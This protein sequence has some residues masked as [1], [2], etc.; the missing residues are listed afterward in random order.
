MAQQ[1]RIMYAGNFTWEELKYNGFTENSLNIL[2]NDLKYPIHPA[3]AYWPELT[4]EDQDILMPTIRLASALF[5]SPASVSFLEN[6]M[7]EERVYLHAESQQAGFN[8][9]GLNQCL[10]PT[11]HIRGLWNQGMRELSDKISWRIFDP[12]SDEFSSYGL[13]TTGLTF[14]NDNIVTTITHSLWRLP[15][16]GKGS[17]IYINGIHLTDLKKLVTLPFQTIDQV[18]QMLRLQ[19]HVATTMCHEMAH[20]VHKGTY[21]GGEPFYMNQS[22]TELG[23]AWENEV[24]GGS[25]ELIDH[26]IDMTSPLT[27]VKWP[28]V[29]EIAKPAEGQI[30]RRFPKG[31]ST[32]YFSEMD[33]IARLQTTDHWTAWASNVRWH[34]DPHLLKIEKRIGV[35]LRNTGDLDPTW[36]ESQSSEGRNPAGYGNRVYRYTDSSLSS[37]Q[38]VESLSKG[39][40]LPGK[41]QSPGA[42]PSPSALASMAHATILVGTAHTPGNSP[43]EFKYPSSGSSEEI[44]ESMS[45]GIILTG[46]AHT[47]PGHGPKK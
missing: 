19:F 25:I 2:A 37:A 32:Y 17:D 18:N 10:P 41:A 26:L 33:W 35:Q 45:Q 6:I 9:W 15:R 38:S 22:V 1:N 16:V 34:T 28:G 47:P 14:G 43:G 40:I 8:L 20:A 30:A 44:P 13:G 11:D 46:T 12:F 24:F 27:V 31:A 5:E 3:F 29:M 7:F 36:R 4:P 39:I 23:R 42:S 21:V